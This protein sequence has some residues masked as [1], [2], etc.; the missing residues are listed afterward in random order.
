MEKVAASLDE[1][2]QKAFSDMHSMYDVMTNI[3]GKAKEALKPTKSTV[4]KII[5]EKPLAKTAL[6]AVGLGAGIDLLP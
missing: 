4:K 6:Q 1:E 3:G 2:S 5:T